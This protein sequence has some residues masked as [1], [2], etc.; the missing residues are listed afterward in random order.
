MEVKLHGKMLL[1]TFEDGE[2]DVLK[3]VLNVVESASY[4][5]I[6]SEKGLL[7]F[8]GLEIDKLRRTIFCNE[9]EVKLTYTEFQILKLLAT[10]PG[11]VFSK[12]QIYDLVWK[13]PYFGNHN[14]VMGHIQNIREK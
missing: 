9:G 5:G 14:I 12:E 3:H 11:I 1:L 2:D 13:E 8:Q 6:C 10:N 7:K 4:Q